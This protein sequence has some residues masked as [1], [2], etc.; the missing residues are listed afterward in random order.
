MNKLPDPLRHRFTRRLVAAALLGCALL[1]GQLAPAR[2]ET[3]DRPAAATTL[4]IVRH[5][6]KSAPNGDIP[7][8][9]EGRDRAALLARMLRDAGVGRIYTSEMV[10]TRETAEPL[11]RRLGV[12]AETVPVQDIDAL[13]AKLRA[14]TTG[15]V[16]LVVN[17]SNT[18][19]KIV[20]KL[21]G[22]SVQPIAEDEYDRLLVVTLS[23]DGKAHVV[24][25]RYGTGPVA[26]EKQGLLEYRPSN[27]R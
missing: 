27:P 5:A 11:E 19:P 14:L 15:S 24:T 10:R 3:L 20:D 8:S 1:S 2:A 26:P 9:A 13:V 18:I 23:G 21:G 7:L 16:A 25:L 22:G 12:K 4:F 6:E 17:H